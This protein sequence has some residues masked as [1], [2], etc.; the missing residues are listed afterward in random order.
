MR[1]TWAITLNSKSSMSKQNHRRAILFLLLLG[2]GIMSQAQRNGMYTDHRNNYLI[3]LQQQDAL[4]GHAYALFADK[5][6]ADS[7]SYVI[8]IYNQYLVNVGEKKINL[9]E[10]FTFDCASFD[11]KDI[12][13]RF[14]QEGKEVRYMVFDQ[15]AKLLFDTTLSLKCKKTP[16]GKVVHYQQASVF[17][18]HGNGIID[19]IPL[20]GRGRVN[21]ATVRISADHSVWIN[22]QVATEKAANQILYADK[23]LVVEAVYHYQDAKGQGPLPER[24]SIV[25]L[26]ASSG[27]RIGETVLTLPQGQHIYPVNACLTDGRTEII[28][29]YTRQ[30][31]KHGRVK[32][33]IVIHQLDTRG[34]SILHTA[35]N[36][37]TTTLLSNNTINGRQLVTNSYLHI[38]HAA[39][40]GND[41]WVLAMQQFSKKPVKVLL[42]GN[43][44]VVYDLKSICFA[45]VDKNARL[46]SSHIENNK[47]NRV[48]VPKGLLDHPAYSGIYLG[49]NSLAD[50]SYFTGSGP[51]NDQVSF[52]YTDADPLQKLT[53]GNVLFKNGQFTTDKLSF[54]NTVNK[55]LIGLIPARFGHTYLI[56]FNQTNGKF[57]FDNIKFNN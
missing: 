36:E 29:S 41:H 47:L 16:A 12:Y 54:S 18:L 50:I 2:T 45:A 38:G 46:Q 42:W 57:D 5:I 13:T 43:K 55:T 11:G 56:S 48:K 52:V 49:A 25:T 1:L 10:R 22:E 19:N 34:S 24:T 28:S 3:P 20:S 17:P 26:D 44:N 14:I 21:A 53:I 15:Q 7:N 35:S 40:V 9:P 30:E 51:D 8:G 6:S 39:R 4:V 33:G 31:V 32:Y 37:L 27:T 23:S